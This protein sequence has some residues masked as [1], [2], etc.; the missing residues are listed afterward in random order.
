MYQETQVDKD[1]KIKQLEELVKELQEENDLLWNYLDEVRENEKAL[2]KEIQIA[3]DDY[4][5]K[6]MKPIG[7]A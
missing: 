4:V 6:N 3:V 7:D 5:M 2:M 1:K